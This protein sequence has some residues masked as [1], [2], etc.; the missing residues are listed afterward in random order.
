MN[1]KTKIILI[2]VFCV[3]LV[4][5]AAEIGIVMARNAAVVAVLDETV[6]REISEPTPAEPEPT[7]AE[8][9]P[10]PEPEPEP[11]PAEPEP[12]EPTAELTE[13]PVAEPDENQLK[14]L[15]ALSRM[16]ETDKLYQ[17]FVVSTDALT[18][19]SGTTVA[20]SV[21]KDR[22]PVRPVAGLLYMGSNIRNADQLKRLIAGQQEILLSAAKVPLLTVVD[23]EGGSVSRL[24][25]IAGALNAMYSYRAGGEE[26]AHAN[27][28]TTAERLLEFGLNADFAPV[29][30]VWSNQSNAVIGDRAYSDDFHE[31]ASL[32][33]AAVEGFHEKHLICT[34][35][36]F[37]GH[38]E[39]T[40]DS[41]NGV[42]TVEKT[43]E[44]LWNGELLPFV[45]GIE[46][47]ADMVM[48]GHLVVPALDEAL[49]ATFSQKI[50]TG[51]LREEL[52][53]EGVIITDALTM[54]GA[55]QFYSGGEACIE[56][57][58]A[59]CDLL[60]EPSDLDACVT[61]LRAELEK[62]SDARLTWERIDESLLRILTLKAKYGILE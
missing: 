59:G 43:A 51:L 11:T 33:S 24:K 18:G 7:P 53:F 13:E 15:D 27:A 57:L 3:F 44:E 56:A 10:A 17:L 4:L 47:G 32:V 39:A 23:E 29:A 8:P 31:A 40:A 52:G 45:S 35:K 60:L 26:T 2:A 30:D 16:S 25:G 12:A 58:S 49:P 28:A 62:P 37:P 36:H 5:L 42:A 14:A 54:E 55:T 61:A 6:R 22:L 38:G 48:V 1:K 9:E 34:L 21:T 50:V 20:G 19:R 41:H 46:A